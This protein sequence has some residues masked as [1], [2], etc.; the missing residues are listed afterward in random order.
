VIGTIMQNFATRF[1]GLRRKQPITVFGVDGRMKGRDPIGFD[2]LVHIKRTGEEEWREMPHEFVKGYGR[3]IGAADMAQA[4]RSG[5]KHRCSGEQAFAVLDL[6]QGFLDSSASGAHYKPV[7]K[8][9]RPAPMPADL[10]F[11]TPD[12]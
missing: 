7:A 12:D 10:P 2:S 5:R 3:S 9:Q 1:S 11:G 8:Y 4:I 6:M